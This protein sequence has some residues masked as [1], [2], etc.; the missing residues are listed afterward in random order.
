MEGL[1]SSDPTGRWG[2]E[3]IVRPLTMPGKLV[4]RYVLWWSRKISIV[5]P[6]RVLDGDGNTVIALTSLVEVVVLEVKGSLC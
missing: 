1:T 4:H 6:Q 2:G 3:H 5:E